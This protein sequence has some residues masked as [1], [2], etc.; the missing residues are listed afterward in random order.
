MA[1]TVLRRRGFL[2]AAVSVAACA[3]LPRGSVADGEARDRR[4]NVVLL[5]A[6]DMGYRDLG[7]FGGY[8]PTPHLDALTR[9]GMRLTRFYAASAVCTPTRASIL[10]GRYPLRFDIRQHFSDGPEHL[11]SGTVTLPKLL[12]EAGYRTGHVGKWHLGGLH[13]GDDGRRLDTMPGPKE[14]GFDF[15]QCQIE[16]QPL[17][18]N[19]GR[20]R[21]LFREGG[22]CLLRDGERVPPSDPY[23][24]RHFTDVNGDYAVELIRRFAREGRPFFLNV[25][26]LVPHKPYEPAPEPHWSASAEPGMRDDQRRFRSMVRHMDAK[27][28]EIVATLRELGLLENTLILFA[29]DN[30]GAYEANIGDLK[31]GK[32]DLHDGGLRVPFIAHWPARI[33]AGGSS[34]ATAGTI[35]LLPTVCEAAGVKLSADLPVDGTSLLGHLMDAAPLPE[36]DLF[37]QLDLYKHLQRH[38]PKPKPYATEVMMS[39]PWKLLTLEGEPVE[40]FHIR[41]DPLEQHNLLVEERD[42]ADAMAATVRAWLAEPRQS[43][44]SQSA[45]R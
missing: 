32:T 35:D 29:S 22:T 30:G 20:N 6:D 31:G 34:D 42:R 45:A 18:G 25:W 38:C 16:Q 27:V 36:R 28:G 44:Q 5:L 9:N 39:G 33:P 24:S 14:H 11:P 43:W 17:R 19:M 2:K 7:C 8:N 23:Y 12:R 37:W 10:T 21:T 13:V 1:R 4:P 40:L 26:W 15:Y 41:R 3:A